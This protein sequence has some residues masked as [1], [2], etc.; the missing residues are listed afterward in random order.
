MPRKVDENGQLSCRL[1]QLPN[2]FV[3]PK[4][5]RPIVSIDEAAGSGCKDNVPTSV[6]KLKFSIFQDD[7][8]EEDLGQKE[9][10]GA[11]AKVKQHDSISS[12]LRYPGSAVTSECIDAENADMKRVFLDQ[13]NDIPTQRKPFPFAVFTD[14][15]DEQQIASSV[16][17]EPRAIGFANGARNP[18]E[19]RAFFDQANDIP[20]QRKPIPFAVFTDSDDEQQVASSVFKEPRAIGFANGARNVSACQDSFLGPSTPCM[21]K[22][23]QSQAPGFQFKLK[24]PSWAPSP[25]V[26][27]KNAQ[28]EIQA[29][30]NKTLEWEKDQFTLYQTRDEEFGDDFDQ[31][32]ADDAQMTRK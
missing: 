23:R 26:H 3:K 12:E 29:M 31:Q 2:Q 13:A 10:A 9:N 28:L 19:K 16:F 18:A 5:L 11:F 24:S 8:E 6:A 7:G 30:F 14:S 20:I 17:K 4:P 25:T 21:E 32:F 15:D 1:G 22:Q 27:T